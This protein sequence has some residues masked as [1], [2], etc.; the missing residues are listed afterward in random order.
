M[1]DKISSLN[2]VLAKLWGRLK[3]VHEAPKH[4]TVIQTVWSQT[5]AHDATSPCDICS[6]A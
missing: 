4:I 5:K 2:L 3:F 1:Q 6:I